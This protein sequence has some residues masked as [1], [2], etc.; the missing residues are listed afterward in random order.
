MKY[1]KSET[2]LPIQFN[3]A[4]CFLLWLKR[5]ANSSQSTTNY[6]SN[7]SP[8]LKAP[9]QGGNE[10]WHRSPQPR[11]HSEELS[12]SSK[13]RRNRKAAARL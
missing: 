1:Q 9:V 5:R 3:N 7:I 2:R 12:V 8:L 4:H 13:L 6:W 10:P 11:L